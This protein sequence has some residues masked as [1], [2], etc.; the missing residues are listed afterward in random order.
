MLNLG[1]GGG[2]PV[3]EIYVDADAC[4]VKAEIYKVAGRT[5]CKVWIVANSPLRLPT[6]C[7]SELVVVSDGFDAA[8]DWIAERAGAA[9]VVVTADIQLADRCVKRNAVVI[10][11]TGRPFTPDSIGSALATRALMQDLRDMGVVGGGNAPMSQQD[12]S[13]FLQT[14]DQAVQALKAG[15]R[16]KFR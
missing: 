6:D 11:P 5:G 15:R 16:P 3:V 4:P 8:D 2:Q 1:K 13:K 10:G 9:D 14:L 12:K 7:V